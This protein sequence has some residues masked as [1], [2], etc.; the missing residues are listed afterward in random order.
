MISSPIPFK[1]ETPARAKSWRVELR[2]AGASDRPA[3]CSTAWRELLKVA[4]GGLV[5]CARRVP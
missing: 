5:T 2:H 3:E 4:R 1:V